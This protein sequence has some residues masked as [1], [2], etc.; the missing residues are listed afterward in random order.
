M[1]LLP[2]SPITGGRQKT[3]RRR[4]F[5]FVKNRLSGSR[6]ERERDCSGAEGETGKGG[7]G[8][9]RRRR[10]LCGESSMKRWCLKSWIGIC[11]DGGMRTASART[12]ERSIRLETLA[13]PEI[14]E[15]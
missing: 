14:P 11:D 1:I 5:P 12:D 2:H 6:A 13:A 4:A 3:Y 8:Q 7:G 10:L 9:K 15:P